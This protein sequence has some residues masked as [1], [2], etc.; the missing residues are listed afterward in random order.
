MFNT[1]LVRCLGKRH[2]FSVFLMQA[3]SKHPGALGMK[4]FSSL[5]EE[6]VENG[7]LIMGY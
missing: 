4:P 5:P 1:M 2:V 6:W 7:C 3:V